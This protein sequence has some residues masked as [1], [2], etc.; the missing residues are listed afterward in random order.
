MVLNSSSM[1]EL[2]MVRFLLMMGIV[3][4]DMRIRS[5]VALL[6]SSKGTSFSGSETGENSSLW[7][8]IFYIYI[9]KCF[10]FYFTIRNSRASLLLKSHYKSNKPADK[11][12]FNIFLYFFSSKLFSTLKQ[13]NL[14]Y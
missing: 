10:G 8:S 11:P 2:A 9:F 5:I 1:R 13:V 7:L 4:R 14:N 12:R 3:F 6:F